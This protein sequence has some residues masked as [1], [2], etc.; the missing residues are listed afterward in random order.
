MQAWLKEILDK[1]TA[2]IPETGQA[3]GIGRNAAYEAANRGDI[4]TI[5]IC[6]KRRVP[7]TWIKNKLGLNI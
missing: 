7:T 5:D 3:F 6:K 2:S 4:P 1:P